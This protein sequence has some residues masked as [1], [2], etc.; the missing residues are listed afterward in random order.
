MRIVIDL[1]SL[2]SE[3][4]FGKLGSYLAKQVIDLIRNRKNHEIFLVLNG[5]FAETI[6]TIRAMFD[7]IL[8][9][10]NIRVW[11]SIGDVK[12]CIQ[13]NERQR[14]ASE[15]IREAFISSLKPD[16]VFLPNIFE[17]YNDNGVTSIGE[18]LPNLKTVVAINSLDSTNMIKDSS[19]HKS[20]II[21]KMSYL[22]KAS[23]IL[24]LPP[25]TMEEVYKKIDLPKEFII[26]SC[27]INETNSKS[28]TVSKETQN[29]FK[30]FEDVFSESTSSS[31]FYFKKRR[32]LAYVSPLLPE[33]NRISNYN[34]NL[35]PALKRFYEIDVI[36]PQ[37]NIT[38]SWITA[39]C[40]IKTVEWFSNHF[41]DYDRIL[42]HLG[43]SQEYNYTFDLL[44]KIPGVVVLHNFYFGKILLERELNEISNHALS[45]ALYKSHG[46]LALADRFSEEDIINIINKYP[47][48]FEIF[49]NA[50]GIITHS[51]YSGRLAH[52]W[53]ENWKD[54]TEWNYISRRSIKDESSNLFTKAIEE[55]YAKTN[56]ILND[57]ILKV[58]SDLDKPVSDSESI[59]LS[60]SIAFSLP[61]LQPMKQL[62]VDITQTH[63]NDFKT[64]IQRVV[65]AI[66]KELIQSPPEGY[67]IE[68]IYLTDIGGHW[69]YRYAREWTST[70]LTIPQ[71]LILDEPIEFSAG[72][73][74]LVADYTP[75]FITL[76]EET[77]VFKKLKEQ[78]IQIQFFLYDLLPIQMPEVFPSGVYG[79]LGHEEW[80]KHVIHV[81]D[82]VICISRS[83]ANELR[84]YL[85]VVQPKRE[86]PLIIDW[87]HLGADIKNSI[88]SF[89][90]SEEEEKKLVRFKTIPSFLMV[91]TI[92]PRKGHLQTL[93]AFTLLWKEGYDVNLIIVGKEGWKSLPEDVRPPIKNIM[94]KLHEHPELNKHLFLLDGI[95]DEY[96]EK[97]YAASTCLIAASLGEGFGLPLIEAAHHKLPIIA[98]DIPIFREVTNGHAYYFSGLEPES[99]ANCIKE[100]LVLKSKKQIPESTNMPML[101]WTESVS[102][103]KEIILKH[104]R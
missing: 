60:Q 30:I 54:I 47:C 34:E 35:I 58:A 82:T 75:G 86:I 77:G 45:I 72:D 78:G 62:F 69:H 33:Q 21:S 28:E 36:T 39:N 90:I 24:V 51:K 73:L 1:Q 68:P 102:Q 81:G 84:G 32:R 20:F 99:L 83:V 11:Y 91:S 15:K 87:F 16:V 13:G 95:S 48:N 103:L 89:G 65:R 41:G 98:R 10:K 94:T 74:L 61:T 17:G 71:G 76:A 27:F 56:N 44:K 53:Y 42:Y 100:W 40:N 55:S 3:N 104:I 66:A 46:Y 26:P 80:I 9:Q 7:Q 63:L 96:L 5:L 50:K 57:L 52:K 88:P 29:L 14:Q 2:Q 22:K 8:P 92:E 70:S 93:E 25:L 79:K 38:E 12:E 6:P 18:F 101:T 4:R 49:Q 67:R 31:K 43:N 85:E 23:R 59:L 64:G 37:D 19:L 97:V